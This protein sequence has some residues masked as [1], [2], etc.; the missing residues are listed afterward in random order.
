MPVNV[1]V[2]LCRQLHDIL[3]IPSQPPGCRLGSSASVFRQGCLSLEVKMAPERGNTN[4]KPFLFCSNPINKS[5]INKRVFSE[6]LDK[7]LEEKFP[8]G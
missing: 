1:S 6:K 2:W 3:Q 7:F 8:P 5:H 4:K